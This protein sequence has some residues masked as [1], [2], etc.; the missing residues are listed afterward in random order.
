MNKNFENNKKLEDINEGIIK[1]R[2]LDKKKIYIFIFIRK[3][4]FVT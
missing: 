2:M 4:D 1:R 3:D